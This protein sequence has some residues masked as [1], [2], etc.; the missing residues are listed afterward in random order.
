MPLLSG[1]NILQE[2]LSRNDAPSTDDVPGPC[3]LALGSE[4]PYNKVVGGASLGDVICTKD[5]V[6]PPDG[7][8]VLH[9]FARL[10]GRTWHL[11][12][13]TEGKLTEDRLPGG[14]FKSGATRVGVELLNHS[15]KPVTNPLERIFFITHPI[16]YPPAND[17]RMD[18]SLEGNVTSC[19][20]RLSDE[21]FLAM[22]SDDLEMTLSVNK[23]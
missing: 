22:F 2:G 1:T 12:V 19:T 15:S 21:Q 16:S 11:S 10:K 23:Q 7:R 18:L 9:G 14:D 8:N 6:I 17:I 5:A 4:Q 3:E 13:F 20:K